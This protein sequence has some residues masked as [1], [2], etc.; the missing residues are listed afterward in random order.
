MKIGPLI[1]SRHLTD[2][3]FLHYCTQYTKDTKAIQLGAQKITTITHPNRSNLRQQVAHTLHTGIPMLLMSLH[4][5]LRPTDVSSESK[6]KEHLI[7]MAGAAIGGV[8]GDRDRD[9]GGVAI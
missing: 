2:D 6:K 7:H 5:H 8:G 9:D 1:A 4:L 3:I